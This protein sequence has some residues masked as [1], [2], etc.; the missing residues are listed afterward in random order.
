MSQKAFTLTFLARA[1]QC[2]TVAFR[3]YL[4]SKGIKPI[5]ETN[6]TKMYGYDG[7]G[8]V[9]A[10]RNEVDA[11]KNSEAVRAK[12]AAALVVGREVLANKMAARGRDEQLAAL[13]RRID[14]MQ[15]TMDSILDHLTKAA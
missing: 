1:A 8:A 12:R 3:D 14:N 11:R 4:D 5:H 2:T 6:R 13:Q 10:Y 7:F 9:S 15:S